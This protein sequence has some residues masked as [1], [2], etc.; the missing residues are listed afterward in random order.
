[1][2]LAIGSYILGEAVKVGERCAPLGCASLGKSS[3]MP[4]AHLPSSA[5]FL[6][7][8]LPEPTQHRQTHPRAALIRAP[9]ARW[10][11]TACVSVI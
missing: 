11:A 5:V 1:M 10:T 8:A 7:H 3:C 6:Q 2:P 4:L 9:T